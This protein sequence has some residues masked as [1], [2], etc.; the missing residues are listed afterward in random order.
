MMMTKKKKM[1]L[2]NWKD[3]NKQNPD[4]EEEQKSIKGRQESRA[5]DV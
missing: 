1:E 3:W 4:L 2:E 5:V